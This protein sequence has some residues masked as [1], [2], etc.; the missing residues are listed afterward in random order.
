MQNGKPQRVFCLF[1]TTRKPRSERSVR[2]FC[3]C[4]TLAGGRRKRSLE[5]TVRASQAAISGPNSLKTRVKQG[6]KVPDHKRKPLLVVCRQP[7]IHHVTKGSVVTFDDKPIDAQ[8]DVGRG[9]GRPLVVVAKGMV[10]L[11]VMAAASF[12]MLM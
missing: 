2:G 1:G 3:L 5:R 11:S 6:H 8:K 10:V 9:K 12:A 7:R 4:V